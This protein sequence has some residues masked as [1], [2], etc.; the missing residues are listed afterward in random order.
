MRL[1]MLKIGIRTY[2]IRSDPN[3]AAL[4]RQGEQKYVAAAAAAAS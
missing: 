2:E 1:Y 3:A 4:V